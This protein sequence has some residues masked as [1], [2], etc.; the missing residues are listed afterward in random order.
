M[1]RRGSAAAPPKRTTTVK[2]RV[3]L[4]TAAREAGVNLPATLERALR[5]ELGAAKGKDDAAHDRL[6]STR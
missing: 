6:G 4:L 3:D 5:E 1:T 2:I